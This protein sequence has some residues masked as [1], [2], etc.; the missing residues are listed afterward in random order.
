MRY[1]WNMTPVERYD[2][3]IVFDPKTNSLFA[4]RQRALTASIIRTTK[5]SNRALGFAWDPFRD[6]RTSV[7]GAYGFMVDQPMTSVVTG[8]SAN[9][10]L[11]I[12]L[13]SVGVVRLDN[14]I[15]A[16]QP[17]ALAPQTVDNRYRNGY[18][19]SW[20]L[21]IQRELKPRLAVMAGYF[22]SK[23]THL[24]IS[25]NINQAFA[26]CPTLCNTI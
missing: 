18:V 4:C 19:Q 7:R 9:P 24:R 6:G 2:R 10:P 17:A 5:T 3:F 13:T 22:G 26:R 25:R 15:A 1:E 21:N 8:T 23:G 20:N 16:A 14:A 11:A 12:P